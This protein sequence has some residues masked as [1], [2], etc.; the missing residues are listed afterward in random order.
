MDVKCF[1]KLTSKH[2]LA[3]QLCGMQNQPIACQTQASICEDRS[4]EFTI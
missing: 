4:I 2:V 3:C 1:Q